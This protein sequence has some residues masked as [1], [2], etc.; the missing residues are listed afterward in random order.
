MIETFSSVTKMVTVKVLIILVVSKSWHLVQL[1]VNNA[2]LHDDLAEEVYMHFPL[3]YKPSIDYKGQGLV[4][5]V[6]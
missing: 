2:Y 6:V 1:D 5:L 4:W 3:G